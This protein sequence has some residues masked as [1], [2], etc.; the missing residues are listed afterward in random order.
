MNTKKRRPPK[1]AAWILRH[2]AYQDDEISILGDAEEDYTDIRAQN[3]V[4]CAI[5]SY[6]IQVLISLPTFLKSY[7]YWSVVMFRNYLKTA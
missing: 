2:L 5:C 4:F 6:W 1:I 7:V 3:G